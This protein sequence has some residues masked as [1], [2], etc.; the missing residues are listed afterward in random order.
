M[1][2]R[3][4]DAAHASGPSRDPL[5]E[6]PG[7]AAA[8]AGS[9]SSSGRDAR[10]AR[11]DL[12]DVRQVGWGLLGDHRARRPAVP[13]ARRGVGGVHRPAAHAVA[14][15]AFGA[16]IGGDAIGNLTPLGPLVG[17]PAKAAFVRGTCRAGTGAHGAGDRE[18]AL[19]AVGAAMIAAG[20]VALL[21]ALP[22]AAR[23]PRRRRAWRSRGRRRVRRRRCGCCG[24]ARAHQPRAR[25]SC[26]RRSDAAR[27]DRA[28]PG[29]R[30]RSTRSRR[31]TAGRLPALAA[32]ELGFH[33]LG[34]TEIY[35]TL[36][37]LQRAAPVPAHRV[38]VRNRESPDH[39]RVQVR[40]ASGSAWMKRARLVRGSSSDCRPNRPGPGI[41]R[42]ARML[43]W[44]AAGERVLVRE[45]R[46]GTGA[47]R[48]SSQNPQRRAAL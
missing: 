38:P 12:A 10:R 41:I 33:V 28:R 30:R 1:N 7:R 20:M 27:A 39:G 45:G 19:H 22:A 46:A 3:L 8:A 42:K 47:V 4:Y 16:V 26:Q 23:H 32:A 18:R 44:A 15:R 13:A 6:P 43:F 36:W 11:G 40:A 2:L 24:A 9:C 37:L 35:L 21:V 34:V 31:V 29:S 25:R 14:A 17:E 5:T 48:A